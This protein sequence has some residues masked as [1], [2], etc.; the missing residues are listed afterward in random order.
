MEDLEP[1]SLLVVG[2]GFIGWNVAKEG[3]RRGWRVDSI[4]LKLPDNSYKVP[5][6]NYIAA[7]ITIPESLVRIT[8]EQYDYVINVGGY[9]EHA[10][11]ITGGQSIIQSHFNGLLNLVERLDWSHLKRFIQIGSS[12]EY[13]NAPAPQNE[14]LRELPISP[15]SLGKV[16]STHFAQMMH[17]TEGLPF[18]VLRLFLVYGPGQKKT[19]FIPQ[20]ISGCIDDENF[21]T[22]A[23]DQIRDFCYVDDVVRAI[24]MVFGS[25]SSNGQILNVA[26]GSPISIR[27]V[28][29]MV[30]EL[31]KKG[32]PQFGKIDYRNGENMSLYADINKIRK[33]VGWHPEVGLEAGISRTIE[34]M[35]NESV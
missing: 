10:R 34:W 4:A 26:S 23:G 33:L 5:G 27:N 20:I 19:R 24:Y 6:V 16:A 32:R 2:G 28:I 8:S 7:D 30:C 22:S 1:P 14:M 11:F 35:Q 31:T 21:P 18:A 29:Q 3:I 13:G 9:I 25:D 12:D 17:R 15:Y